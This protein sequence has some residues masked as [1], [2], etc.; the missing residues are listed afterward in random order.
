MSVEAN[1]Q[2]V[3]QEG[4]PRLAHSPAPDGTGDAEQ[5][6]QGVEEHETGLQA[7]LGL[8]KE[9]GV[10][11]RFRSAQLEGGQ[12]VLEDV[13]E[14]HDDERDAHSRDQSP[15]EAALVDGVCVPRAS[16]SA[17]GWPTGQ[18]TEKPRWTNP[19]SRQYC[20]QK[21]SAISVPIAS[22]KWNERECWLD[23]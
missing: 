4:D 19:P 14:G 9:R 22:G 21:G 16:P 3:A 13:V 10:G 8:F 7:E 20:I 1:L 6:E 12:P 17:G 23:S 2:H 5:Q 18:T 11:L 15:R